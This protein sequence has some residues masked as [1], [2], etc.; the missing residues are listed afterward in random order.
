M[1]H[2]GDSILVIDARDHRS[3]LIREKRELVNLEQMGEGGK[4]RIAGQ[5]YSIPYEYSPGRL[6]IYSYVSREERGREVGELKRRGWDAV[7]GPA[8]APHSCFTSS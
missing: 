3:R 2:T 1:Q 6:K 8:E 4:A 5:I 7:L